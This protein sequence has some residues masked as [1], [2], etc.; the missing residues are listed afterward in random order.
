MQNECG[1]LRVQRLN[2]FLHSY[3]SATRLVAISYQ[4][5]AFTGMR[6]NEAL[7]LR[8]NDLD[9]AAKTLTCF[10]EYLSSSNSI[11]V[12]GRS[13]P[14]PQSCRLVARAFQTVTR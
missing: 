13:H 9:E 7:A 12:I 2:H 5:A 4:I 10:A 14:P 1:D 3:I 8:W 11:S 6:R